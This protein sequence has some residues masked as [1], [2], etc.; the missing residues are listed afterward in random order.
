MSTL[1]ETH[2]D[3][4]PRLEAASER[5]QSAHKAAASVIFGQDV[6]I[7]RTLVTILSGGH[8]LLIG[9]P[10]LAKTLLVET[11][12][13]RARSRRQARAVHAR[14]HALRHHRL[15]SAGGR[16]RQVALVP[17][18]QGPDLHPAA[19]GRRDQPR[20]AAHAVGA[21]A[22]DAGA[23]RHG[24]RRALR[25]PDAVPRARDAEPARARRHLSAARSAARPLPAADRRDLPGRAR[26][27][28][29]AV[30]DDRHRRAPPRGRA[31]R[32]TS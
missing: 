10:G 15:G 27:A 9:V 29:H 22:G 1:T 31:H 17:P 8:A 2:A 24:R 21:A 3:I 28:A 23:P 32:R 7:E 13:T 6:V 12:G 4:V 30:C 20:L 11:L 5:V 19:D 14:P 16:A 18:R 26:R 25:H